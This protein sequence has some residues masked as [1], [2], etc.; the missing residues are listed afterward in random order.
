VTLP[1]EAEIWSVLLCLPLVP[2]HLGFAGGTPLFSTRES[3]TRFF[4]CRN[5]FIFSHRVCFV[6]RS[7]PILADYPLCLP[8]NVSLFLR[9]P[10]LVPFI[11]LF[12]HDSLP[13]VPL[14]VSLSGPQP[15]G[16]LSSLRGPT[17]PQ[18]P[19]HPYMSPFFKYFFR[20]FDHRLCERREY[21]HP[22][23]RLVH[24][25][26][27]DDYPNKGKT[28]RFMAASR[29]RSSWSTFPPPSF[30]ETCSFQ[31]PVLVAAFFFPFFS[32]PAPPVRLSHSSSEIAFELRPPRIP[33]HFLLALV[34]QDR[35]FERKLA[36]HSHS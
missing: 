36:M 24:L 1:C 8:L 6:S 20:L 21:A 13:L 9:S 18:A 4:L 28:R 33:L 25:A 15:A 2:F 22:C 29:Y 27:S 31:R 30:S 10:F 14:P 17:F 35:F 26:A 34:C 11:F 16:H 23:C 19:T 7:L 12:S 3:I 5:F 32:T